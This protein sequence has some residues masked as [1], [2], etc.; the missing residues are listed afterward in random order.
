MSEFY[1][2]MLGYINEYMPS[3][4]PVNLTWNFLNLNIY[5]NINLTKK[6]GFSVILQGCFCIY[7]LL[8]KSN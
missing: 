8:L 5:Y 6:R 4:I 2:M 1:E 7:V 3:E